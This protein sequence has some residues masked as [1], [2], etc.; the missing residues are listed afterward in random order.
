MLPPQGGEEQPMC[1]GTPRRRSVRSRAAFLPHSRVR[2]D[3]YPLLRVRLISTSRLPSGLTVTVMPL[4]SY[5][6]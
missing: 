6:V 5:R 2:H 3:R 4:V 1:D